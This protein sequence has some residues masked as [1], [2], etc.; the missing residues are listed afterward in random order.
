MDTVYGTT[1][2]FLDLV[3]T[4]T[5]IFNTIT[6]TTATITGKLTVGGIDIGQAL[7]AVSGDVQS[8]KVKDLIST[9]TLTA[10]NLIVLTSFSSTNATT[11]LGATTASGVFYVSDTTDSNF[12]YYGIGFTGT[13][14]TNASIKTEGG[15]KSLGNVSVGKVLYAGMNDAGDKTGQNPHN[16][17]IDGV[18]IVNSMQ[19]AGTYDNI[20]STVAKQTIDRWD[21]NTYTTAKYLVQVKDGN[22]IQVEEIMLAYNGTNVYMAEYGIIYT[23]ASMGFFDADVSGSNVE[24]SFTPTTLTTNMT[25]QVVRQSILTSVVNH[26]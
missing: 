15:I 19:S 26:F 11:F 9:G 4:G 24:L 18:F 25:I 20:A 6:G 13:T 17:A 12:N 14:S 22:N 7:S 23:D 3:S 2:T 21:K 10:T 5:I 8:F 16:K 1:G